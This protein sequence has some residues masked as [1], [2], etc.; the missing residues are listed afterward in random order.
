MVADMAPIMSASGTVA[1]CKVTRRV[2]AT[3]FFIVNVCFRYLCECVCVGDGVDQK[4]DAIQ[5]AE[6]FVYM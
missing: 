3:L 2:S 4:S 6:V 1:K 5:I